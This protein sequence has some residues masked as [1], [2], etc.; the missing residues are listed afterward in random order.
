MNAKVDAQNLNA[1]S[2]LFELDGEPPHEKVLFVS[3][4]KTSLRAII[5]VHNTTRGPGFGGCR[6]WQY[7]SDEEALRDALRLSHGMSLKNAMADLP[8]GGGKSVIIRGD[9]Q[10]NRK[11][12]FEA[13]GRAVHSLDGQ[14]I[15]GEDVG[16]TVD[17]LLAVRS[18]TPYASGIPRDGGFG[19]NPSP[20]TALGVYVAIERAANVLLG[21]ASLDGVTVAVQGLGSV[22]WNL[23]ERLHAAG[24]K[25]I[26]ADI[27][28]SRV[29]A[30]QTRFGAQ[31]VDVNEIVTQ[32]A[33]V[34]APCALGAVLNVSTIA[35]M[36]CKIVAGAANNQLAMSEDA[37]RLHQRSIAYLPDYVVNAGGIISCVREYEGNGDDAAVDAEVIRIAD[38]IADLMEEAGAEGKSVADVAYQHAR[39]KIG[40]PV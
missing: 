16:T 20:K 30:A 8:Y 7:A 35:E 2:R 24:C 13:F 18:V 12:L 9:R 15:A 14:Y 25:L 39:R 26:V 22:G 4:P 33:D 27:D 32:Q 37:Q 1:V 29:A 19:G 23:A 3:D 31:I 21:A 28:A 11:E 5:A 36:R 38:R 17:D 40:A 34:F 6:M 10:L